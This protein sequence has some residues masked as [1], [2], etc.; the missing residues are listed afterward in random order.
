VVEVI[1]MASSQPLTD[2]LDIDLDS[3]SDLDLD[4]D[5]L[6]WSHKP[7]SLSKAQVAQDDSSNDS[8][9]HRLPTPAETISSDS[10]LS[11]QPTPFSADS[12]TATLEGSTSHGPLISQDDAQT[13]PQTSHGNVAP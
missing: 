3:D 9:D 4:L 1:D 12:D 13:A 2:G 8:P 5:E 10:T 7:Y 6:T 11:H